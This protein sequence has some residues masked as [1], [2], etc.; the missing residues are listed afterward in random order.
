M[1]TAG[2]QT[3][4][5]CARKVGYYEARRLSHA[6]GKHELNLGITRWRSMRRKPNAA[7]TMTGHEQHARAQPA[8]RCA[9]SRWRR[10][11]KDRSAG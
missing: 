6:F 9:S 8:L 3:L 4:Q 2:R 5:L 7:T 10:L 1:P 11:Y